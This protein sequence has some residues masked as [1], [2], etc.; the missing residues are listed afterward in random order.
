MGVASDDSYGIKEGII[1]SY[2]VI[3]ANGKYSIV[4]GLDIDEFSRRMMD[5]TA[6]EL[7]EEREQALS[8]LSAPK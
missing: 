5:A 8:F 7:W 2:P 1:Y 4:K 3:C 6:T